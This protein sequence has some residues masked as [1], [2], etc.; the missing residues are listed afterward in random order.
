MTLS[1]YFSSRSFFVHCSFFNGLPRI[2]YYCIYA[3]INCP[4]NVS[5]FPLLYYISNL[6]VVRAFSLFFVWTMTHLLLCLPV[7]F[8]WTQTIIFYVY[9]LCNIMRV[10]VKLKT[11]FSEN[12]R[13]LLT[14]THIRIHQYIIKSSITTKTMYNFTHTQTSTTKNTEIN[15]M[16]TTK[17]ANYTL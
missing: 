5:Y 1:I 6:F 11:F 15:T 10:C 9:V 7:D 3:K 12:N 17:L 8:F 14:S 4:L 13:F 16:I 2:I